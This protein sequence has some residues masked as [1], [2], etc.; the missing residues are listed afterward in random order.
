MAAYS[1]KTIL[2]FVAKGDAAATTSEKGKA[3][4]DLIC[5]VFQKIPG[6]S[7]TQ[8]NAKNTYESEEIDVAF[9]N[10]QDA[11]GL[12]FLGQILIVECKNWK[13][14]VGSSEVSWLAWKIRRRSLE[15]GILVAANGITGDPKDGKDSHDIV[16]AALADGIRLL[17]ITLD[18]LQG[19]QTSKELVMLL[20]RKMLQLHLI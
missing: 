13:I 10:D 4:E 1:K 8:R 18:E 9:F 16:T 7:L 5:Y 20:K 11:A 14:P 19:L 15:C 2:E 12:N 3:L 6:L 17:V